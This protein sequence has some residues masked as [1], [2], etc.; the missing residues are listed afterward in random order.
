MSE[1]HLK[2]PGFKYSAFGPFTKNKKRIK[3]L[4]KT[5]KIQ[6]IFIKMK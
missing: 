5:Q 2:Q 6:D 3:K 4:R 1:M